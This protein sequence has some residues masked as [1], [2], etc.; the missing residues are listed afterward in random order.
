MVI[1]PWFL[2]SQFQIWNRADFIHVDKD[3]LV[4]EVKTRDHLK[5]S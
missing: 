3:S 4:S 2:D 1:W 5:Y